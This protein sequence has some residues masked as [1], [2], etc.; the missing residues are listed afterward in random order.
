MLPGPTNKPILFTIINL[1]D[2]EGKTLKRNS[3][4][5]APQSCYFPPF[6]F[7]FSLHKCSLLQE[8]NLKATVLSPNFLVLSVE[9]RVGEDPPEIVR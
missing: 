1:M 5:I 3:F 4:N 6:F 7:F 8:K 2:V 9:E